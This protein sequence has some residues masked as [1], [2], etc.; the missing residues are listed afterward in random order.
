MYPKLSDIINDIFGT[1]INLPIQSYGF[2]V[3]LAFIIAGT[4]LYL[5]LK[6]KEKEGLLKPQ[7]KKV[8]KGKPASTQEIVISVIVGFILGFKI[9]EIFF[10]Y[11]F[12][13]DNPQEFLFSTEGNLW[14]GLIFGIASGY[15]IYRNKQ[16]TK[17]DKPEWVEETIHPY[18]LTGMIILVAAISG[19]IGAK[20]F[21]Q[22]ENFDDFLSDPVG[23]ILSFS[24]LTFYGGLIVAT[25]V[26]IYF[27]KRNNISWV[28]LADAIAPALMIAYAIGRIGCQVSGDGDWGIV[29]LATKP[30]WLSF[31]P[32]CLWAYDYPH[33]ILNEGIPIEGCIG[34]HCFKL[35]QPV[36][37]TP[38]Y[39][40]SI[41]F[42]LF[43][44][45]W[46]IRKK[47]KVPGMLF[48]IY[49]ILNGIE[50]FFIEKIRVNE[51]YNIFGK[52]ITQAEIISVVFII[53]GILGIWYFINRYKKSKNVTNQFNNR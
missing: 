6:R 4:T 35:A 46:F 26:V 30:E 28:Y 15:Y 49:L 8:L 23:S 36:F 41:C 51:T 52:E 19:I 39:E 27:A 22:L 32:D 11:S 7:K 34:D 16:K 12:F 44:I 38:V 25:F 20:I 40:T 21:H 1:N 10:N 24:G 43:L 42:I 33:N 13:A 18:Q 50:R 29:N 47:L 14:G 2:F 37:P 45:L 48:S 3:A 53:A 17:L 5:E 9:V 31:L